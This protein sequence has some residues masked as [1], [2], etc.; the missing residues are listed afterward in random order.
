MLAL[1]LNRDIINSILDLLSDNDPTTFLEMEEHFL[2]MDDRE[3]KKE[4]LLLGN[5]MYG[6]EAMT[7]NELVALNEMINKL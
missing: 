5:E 1:D 4:V 3:F 7:S 2:K 6:S